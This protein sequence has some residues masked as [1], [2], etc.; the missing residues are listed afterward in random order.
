M[1]AIAG[2]LVT[3]TGGVISH[4][5]VV[6]REFGLPAVVGVADATMHIADG[7]LIEIDGGRGIVSML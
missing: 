7:R 3:N 2:G 5:A 4:A 6:A 1:F